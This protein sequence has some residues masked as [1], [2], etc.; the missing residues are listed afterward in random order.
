VVLV[1]ADLL[2]SAASYRRGRA[3][4]ADARALYERALRIHE[5]RLGPDHPDTARSRRNLAA[6]TA[7]LDNGP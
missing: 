7:E 3:R 6:L 5:D 2:D 4:Y 1:P